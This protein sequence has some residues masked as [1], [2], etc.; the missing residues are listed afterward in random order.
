MR[1]SY[2][3]INQCLRLAD[4]G[5]W[6]FFHLL[7][8]KS[9]SLLMLNS[10]VIISCTFPTTNIAPIW[11]Y[12]I[13][14]SKKGTWTPNLPMRWCSSSTS[15]S[16]N[17]GRA[18]WLNSWEIPGQAD[19]TSPSQKAVNENGITLRETNS[20]HLKVDD[21]KTILSFWVSAN[22]QVLC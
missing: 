5:W 19:R 11:P 4:I 7:K 9:S 22:F 21:W 16:W 8:R 13:C 6:F 1:R 20:S 17:S 12:K 15:G 14:L 10:Y 2:E 3:M 18:A